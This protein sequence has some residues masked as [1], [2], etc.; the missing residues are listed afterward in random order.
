MLISSMRLQNKLNVKWINTHI[1]YYPNTSS[2]MH[3]GEFTN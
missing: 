2:G 3:F 1:Y